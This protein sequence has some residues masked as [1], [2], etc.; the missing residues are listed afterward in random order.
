MIHPSTRR[1]LLALALAV[2]LAPPARAGSPVEAAVGALRRDDSLKVRTQAAIL[3]GQR[4][5]L[6]AVPALRQAVAE[7]RAAAVRL[8]AVGALARMGAQVAR[9]TLQAAAQAD[10]DPAVRAAA[11]RALAGLGP[12]TLA[13]EEPTGTPSARAVARQALQGHLA[14]LGLPLT[15][16]GE[17][18]VRPAVTVKVAVEAGG[19]RT[20]VSATVSLAAVDG[21][22]RLDLLEGSA[23]ATVTGALPEARLAAVAATVVDAAARGPC[24]ELATRLGRR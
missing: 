13:L 7:D 5:A 19:E 14:R 17:V 18:R 16:P 20:V 24:E 4:G 6:E 21:D 1:R 12:V 3:L 2:G 8:A 9:P 22:G 11:T 23:R 15:G 10:P